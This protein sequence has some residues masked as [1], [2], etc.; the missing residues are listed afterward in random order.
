MIRGDT[1]DVYTIFGE[2]DPP[3]KGIPI[4]LFL[5]YYLQVLLFQLL[6]ENILKTILSEFAIIK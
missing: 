1:F 6:V 3:F 5:E 4:I 2:R